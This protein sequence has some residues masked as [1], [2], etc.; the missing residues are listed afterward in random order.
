MLAAFAA[1][2]AEVRSAAEA[3]FAKKAKP[4]AMRAAVLS[5]LSGKRVMLAQT[6][7]A[8]PHKAKS[9]NARPRQFKDRQRFIMWALTPC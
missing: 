8:P 6:K 7:C 4:N 3:K 2:V 9:A 1:G 5:G